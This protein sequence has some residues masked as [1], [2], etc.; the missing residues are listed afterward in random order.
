MQVTEPQMSTTLS[1]DEQEARRT[2][3]LVVGSGR[4][5]TSLFAG[6]LKRLGF[7]VPQPE[8]PADATNPRGFAESRWVVDFHTRL[9]EEARVQAGDARPSAWAATGRIGLQEPHPARLRTWLEEQFGSGDHLVVK[10]PRL[11]WFLPL[12]RACAKDVGV[13]ARHAMV[14]RHP[15]AVV[16]SKQAAYAGRPSETSRTAGWLNLTLF[17]ERAAREGARAVVRYDRLLD[18]WA[19]EVDR[20][21]TAL[22]LE[23]VT[24]ASWTSMLHVQQFLE[25][26]LSRASADW[27]GLSVPPVLTELADHV[28][29]L[30]CRLADTDREAE[31]VVRAEL[32]AARETY[33]ALYE[34]AEALVDSS[35][36]A[37][38]RVPASAGK[39]P[40]QRTAARTVP[41]TV[42]RRVPLRLRR[43]VLSALRKVNPG[44]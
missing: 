13:S 17:T 30:V 24:N 4:S 33:T 3:V 35:I 16:N 40:P 26:S 28:W 20:V 36:W 19:R 10:D 22:D 5:G 41:T 18:D 32:D 8:V 43:A 1:G 29:E 42:R 14:V 37:A 23:V 39:N 25:P 27:R 44:R 15:A 7:H 31:D 34:T 12:W 2:L 11:A 9:L 21:G 6:A 38:S